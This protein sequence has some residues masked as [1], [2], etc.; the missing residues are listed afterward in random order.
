MQCILTHKW[1]LSFF[2]KLQNSGGENVLRKMLWNKISYSAH[3]HNART[4]LY[5][6]TEM[7]LFYTP[8]PKHRKPQH[9]L[10]ISSSCSA[11]NCSR[12]VSNRHSESLH[13]YSTP[14]MNYHQ[15]CNNRFAFLFSFFCVLCSIMTSTES[16]L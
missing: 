10:C 1:K 12:N 3:R 14:I 13:I 6:C 7:S 4:Q 5:I 15:W 9:N 2:G 16:K 11:L 8:A